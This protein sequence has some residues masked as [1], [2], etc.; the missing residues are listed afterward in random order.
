M[1]QQHQHL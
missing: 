1:T